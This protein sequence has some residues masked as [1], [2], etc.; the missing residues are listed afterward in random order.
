MQMI[1]VFEQVGTLMCFA[2]AGFLF[3]K[4]RVL[5]D[6]HTK[7]LSVLC[8]YFFAPCSVFKTFSVHFTIGYIK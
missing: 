7:A 3:G 5:N 1:T 4:A 6:M 8:V 2:L